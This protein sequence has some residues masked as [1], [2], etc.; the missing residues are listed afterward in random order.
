MFCVYFGAAIEFVLPSAVPFVLC[1]ILGDK[2]R[3][4]FGEARGQTK[5]NPSRVLLQTDMSSSIHIMFWHHYE[6]FCSDRLQRS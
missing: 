4:V 5:D 1:W 6:Q 3:Q 2:L